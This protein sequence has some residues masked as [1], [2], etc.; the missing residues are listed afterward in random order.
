MSG[1]TNINHLLFNARLSIRYH[2]RRR[3]FFDVVNLCASAVAVIF[4][5]GAI[6]ALLAKSTELAA[7]SAV[8]V[9]VFAG[10]N[11]VLR[12]SERA[13]QHHDLTR[14]FIA[15]EI[16]LIPA[17]ESQFSELYGEK[18]LIEADELPPLDILAVICHNDQV[19]AE[20]HGPGRKVNLWFWQ[21]MF[22]HFFDLPPRPVPPSTQSS[23]T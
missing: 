16:K 20:G 11:L 2:N 22:A 10:V 21:R 3:A 13:R 6:G 12:S 7:W 1:I 23:T 5:S 15:L 17:T 14:R 8:V 9:T 18:L 19:S 4:S